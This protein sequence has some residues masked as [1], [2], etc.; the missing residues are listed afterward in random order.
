MRGIRK[1]C[2]RLVLGFILFSVAVVLPLRWIDPPGSMLMLVRSWEH[3]GERY[4]VTKQ[5]RDIATLPRHAALAVVV[6]EDQRFLQHYGVDIAAIRK[7]MAERKWRGELRGASTITQQVAKNLYLWNGRSWLRK[8]LEAWFAMLVDL[9]WSK[10]RVME[11]YLNI[12]EWGPGVFGLAAA[13]EYHFQRDVSQLSPW[14]SALLASALPSPLTY[15]PA[16]PSPQLSER[17]RWNLAQQR[18]LGGESWL[19]DMY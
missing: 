8:G 9:C 5:W 7:A 4:D 12:A 3:R 17:A 14:Q 18:R 19:A 6:S 10:Q 15:T 13:S 1:W 16:S 11:V 2:V